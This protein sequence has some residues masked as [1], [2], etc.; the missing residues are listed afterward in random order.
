M[1]KQQ[2]SRLNQ[3]KQKQV[4]RLANVHRQLLSFSALAMISAES[5][6][7][8][9]PIGQIATNVGSQAT[10]LTTAL[11]FGAMFVGVGMVCYSV[12]G[13]TLGRKQDSR[14]YPVGQMAAI[15]LGGAVLTTIALATGV[16]SA[17]VFGADQSSAELGGGT[18]SVGLQ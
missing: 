4:A 3:F 1:I 9:V 15:G 13:L 12:Y 16:L 7:Q 14:E 10:G 5:H 6:A 18:G 8:A 17:T 2:M 11:K